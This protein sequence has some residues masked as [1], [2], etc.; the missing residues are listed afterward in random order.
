MDTPPKPRDYWIHRRAMAWLSFVGIVMLAGFVV[1]G[2]QFQHPDLMSD[3][4]WLLGIN[5][6]IWSG[7]A[8]LV[9]VASKFRR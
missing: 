2:Y 1:A 3:I 6:F 8:S 9:D 5:I 7:G 4:I